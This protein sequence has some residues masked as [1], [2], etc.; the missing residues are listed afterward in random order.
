MIVKHIIFTLLI[1][2][3]DSQLTSFTSLLIDAWKNNPIVQFT[4]RASGEV[5]TNTVDNITKL[6]IAIAGALRH[7]YMFPTLIHSHTNVIDVTDNFIAEFNSESNN[8]DANLNIE[9]LIIK[10]GYPVEE[11]TVQTEDGYIL[12]MYRIPNNGSVVFLMHGLLGSADDYVI[13]G[14]ESGLAYL[15]SK[16]GYDVWMGNARGNKHSRRHVEY[17]PSESVFWDFTWHE[18]GYYDLPAM[19]DYALE[20]SN[21]E[22][23]KFIGHSQGTTAFFVMASEKVH[24]NSKIS[25]MIALSPVAFM[26]NAKSPIVRLLAP[27]GPLIHSFTKALG[28]YE[29]LPDN[30]MMRILKHLMC[31]NGVLAE[32][33]CN[34]I[35]FLMAGFDLGQLNVTNLPVM[36]GHSPSGASV[37]QIAHYGQSVISNDFKKF[38]YGSLEN[39]RLYGKSEPPSYKLDRISAPVSLFYSEADWLAHPDD[40]SKLYDKLGN[41]VDLHK[42]PY[43]QFNHLD[44]LFAKDFKNLIYERLRKLLSLF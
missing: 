22:T 26:A 9:E 20:V 31:G 16:E 10:Y 15:L 39:I 43:K 24:Y 18:I 4:T 5:I 34:N 32:I 11:H 29:L 41:A 44:F 21:S 36:F 1:V 8:E 3:C 40:V 35:I 13:A 19:I 30:T 33:L 25:L 27:G 42:I 6:P 38:D 12:N 14:P 2:S 28:I 17:H 23:L 37:K 7:V